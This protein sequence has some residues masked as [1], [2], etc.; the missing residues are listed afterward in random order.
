MLVSVA[1]SDCEK[2]EI[3]PSSYGQIMQVDPASS[4]AATFTANTDY[5]TLRQKEQVVT[6][7]G[8]SNALKSET[9]DGRAEEI[10]LQI[11]SN[12]GRK[13]G[14]TELGYTAYTFYIALDRED[15][16]GNLT[17]KVVEDSVK[18]AYFTVYEMTSEFSDRFNHGAADITSFEGKV[19]SV[20][21][22]KFLRL[23]V[24]WNGAKNEDEDCFVFAFDG[25]ESNHNAPEGASGS[26]GVPTDGDNTGDPVGG[27]DSGGSVTIGGETPSGEPEGDANSGDSGSGGE[28]DAGDD[29]GANPGICE[30]HVISDTETQTVIARTYCDGTR[31]TVTIQKQAVIRYD[32]PA[33][34]P[35]EYDG[36]TIQ[37]TAKAYEDCIKLLEIAAIVPRSLN[38]QS[39]SERLEDKIS[40][41]VANTPFNLRAVLS[42][43]DA[44]QYEA[45]YQE[46][47]TDGVC[48]ADQVSAYLDEL[49]DDTTPT[50]TLRRSFAGLP[51]P[52]LARLFHLAIA[53]DGDPLMLDVIE[54]TGLPLSE[55]TENVSALDDQLAYLLAIRKSSSELTDFIQ[56]AEIFINCVKNSFDE[57][58]E[59]DLNFLVNNISRFEEV[60]EFAREYHS[61]NSQYVVQL[62][63]NKGF[64]F[65][66]FKDTKDHYLT[67][68]YPLSD[69]F[70]PQAPTSE[71][72]NGIEIRNVDHSNID[73][74]R[75][76]ELRTTMF[77]PRGNV[78]DLQTN[79]KLEGVNRAEG[80]DAMSELQCWNWMNILSEACTKDATEE[81]E[82]ATEEYMDRFAQDLPDDYSNERLRQELVN[83]PEWRNVVKYVASELRTQ[84]IDRCELDPETCNNI[85]E[86]LPMSKLDNLLRPKFSQEKYGTRGLTFLINDTEATYFHIPRVSIN[87]DLGSWNA[88][89]HMQIIDHF[90]LDYNDVIKYQDTRKY[91]IKF[92]NGFAGWYLLQNK[93]KYQP[94]RTVLKYRIEVSGEF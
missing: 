44:E 83:T 16:F 38:Y 3:I 66:P 1:F 31:E 43:I 58:S 74:E 18:A 35:G 76:V 12:P 77:G 39:L 92:G 53:T 5:L 40:L 52:I 86:A 4:D 28:S 30:E 69:Q 55:F 89:I 7:F 70:E 42:I 9:D 25:P 88:T 27:D 80:F 21:L 54:Y 8:N 51:Y 10:I 33:P 24:K 57:Y 67:Y 94:F 46:H 17:V 34:D 13:L 26:G 23:F 47:Y 48:I 59:S 56:R 41:S 6:Y 75:H 14:V 87:R 78:A 15:R 32:E 45:C 11:L 49:V 37:A 84:L 60:G 71:I 93:Y 65:I 68:Y 91:L 85:T 64:E 72:D 29:R 90:G 62:Y 20:S 50:G 19:R 61:F 2:E 73:I 36:P 79:Q 82:M 63:R 22:N 81:I